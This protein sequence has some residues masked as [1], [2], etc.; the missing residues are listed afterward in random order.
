[1]KQSLIAASL[2][3]SLTLS[4]GSATVWPC[5]PRTRACDCAPADP[6]DWARGFVQ[7][8]YDHQYIK[9]GMFLRASLVHVLEVDSLG[10][11]VPD[12]LRGLG[13]WTAHDFRIET[14]WTRVNGPVPPDAVR[15]VNRSSSLCPRP[16]WRVGGSYLLFA[17]RYKGRLE[18]FLD[19]QREHPSELPEAQRAFV[20]LDSLLPRH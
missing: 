12:S 2:A 19:C 7:G 15:F 10:R 14:V 8:L 11:P 3:V 13:E 18:T 20:V 9:E 16:R 6:S 5:V 4:S 17:Y 1:M